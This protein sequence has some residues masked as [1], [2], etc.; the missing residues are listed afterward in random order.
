MLTCKNIPV[1]AQKLIDGELGFVQRVR[2]RFHLLIC[3]YCR[4]Y[5]NQLLLTLQ[6]MKDSD[7]LE[8]ASPS[9]AEIDQIVARLKNES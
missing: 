1:E 6:T 7:L 3:K 9:E 2:V 8:E 5:V 4:R